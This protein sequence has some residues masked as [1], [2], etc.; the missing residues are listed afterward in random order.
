MI[1]KRRGFPA[2]FI[3]GNQGSDQ[4]ESAPRTLSILGATGSIGV[5]TLDVVRHMGGRDAF[6]VVAL[7]GSGNVTLLAKQASE[8]GAKIAVTADERQYSALKEA[9]AGT[10][11]QAASGRQA[12]I[13]AAGVPVDITMA[14]IVGMAGLE[15]TLAAAKNGSA[16]A[17][18]N[19]ECLVAAGQ[20]FKDAI[21]QAGGTLL[22]VD[23]E[24]NAV[25]QLLDAKHHDALERVILTASGGPFRTWSREQMAGVTVETARAHPNWSMGL[26]ISI[27]SASM[28]NKALEMIEAQHLFN[29]A[30]DQIE[31]IVHPQSII[32]SMA[33]YHDGSILAQLGPSDMRAAIG[34]ALNYPQRGFLPV[35]RLDFAKLS[36]LDFAAPDEVCFPALRLAREA[37]KAGGLSGAVLNGAKESALEAFIAGRLPFLAMA[38]VVE[39][40]MDTIDALSATG[41]E[42]VIAAD[43]QARRLAQEA[44][45]S[46]A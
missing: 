32:H 42:A 24:H 10:G 13:D 38:D 1:D 43:N 19:K 20:L 28:F 40:V 18:A 35:E 17:L 29:L 26:K 12:L 23:S 31:V 3:S 4:L 15:P 6:D 14:A 25:F 37:M 2:V 27:D 30:P 33:A 39:T 7:T 9:L 11:I 46:R 16:I 44:I 22:P 45:A 5:N 36:R 34:Y 8:F 21:A 41:I